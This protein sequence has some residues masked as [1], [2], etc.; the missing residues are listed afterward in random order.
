M[1][2]A[3]RVGCHEEGALDRAEAALHNGSG[4]CHRVSGVNFLLPPGWVCNLPLYVMIRGPD[5]G[6]GHL[7][8]IA[9]IANID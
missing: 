8:N 1:V 3:P 2:G 6:V 9:F 5:F 4:G 7:C